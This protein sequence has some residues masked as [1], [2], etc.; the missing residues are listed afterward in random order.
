MR[1]I[2]FFDG[3][4]YA[5]NPYWHRRRCNR[6]HQSSI[7]REAI[8]QWSTMSKRVAV[9]VQGSISSNDEDRMSL[10]AATRR[11][12]G[13]TP[14]E[15]VGLEPNTL[16]CVQAV[17]IALLVARD[18]KLGAGMAAA[19][20][21]KYSVPYSSRTSTLFQVGMTVER[22]EYLSTGRWAQ[23]DQPITF[24]WCNKLENSILPA[25]LP[26]LTHLHKFWLGI[27]WLVASCLTLFYWVSSGFPRIL[28]FGSFRWNTSACCFINT[29]LHHTIPCSHD[30]YSSHCRAL[31]ML[32][33]FDRPSNTD[34]SHR[35]PPL[36]S[37]PVI[38]FR[39]LNWLKTLPEISSTFAKNWQVTVSSS[40]YLQHSV[41]LVLVVCRTRT[42]ILKPIS[43]PSCSNSH[44]PGFINHPKLKDAG[45]VF[46]IAVNDPFVW[47]LYPRLLLG[48]MHKSILSSLQGLFLSLFCFH[49]SFSMKETLNKTSLSSKITSLYH[50]PFVSSLIS[51]LFILNPPQFPPTQTPTISS[52]WLPNP[53]MKAWG[54]SLDAEKSSK[55]RF[56]G[57][58]SGA[59]TRALDTEFDSVKIFG[60]N[61]SKRYVVTVEDGKVK[62]V[63]IE[64][65][66]T[67][68]NGEF[69]I[70][71]FPAS[72]FCF[73]GVLIVNLGK[74]ANWICC[75][76]S[77]HSGESAR[78]DHRRSASE[79]WFRGPFVRGDRGV[80]GE[81]GGVSGWSERSIQ[82]CLRIRTGNRTTTTGL[83]GWRHSRSRPIEIHNSNSRLM[84]CY[85]SKAQIGKAL[86]LL[87]ATW[88]TRSLQRLTLCPRSREGQQHSVQCP[89]NK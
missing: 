28:I 7:W 10:Q 88:C 53:S 45:K 35:L 67:G 15:S 52:S 68:V 42:S 27:T 11:L 34:Y 8:G 33:F 23:T 19:T 22:Y 31:E 64:P 57:D 71:V 85:K 29:V 38:L 13:S 2:I 59:F 46:V 65:D 66:N 70:P 1:K 12:A 16:Y 41:R 4:I 73:F 77:I 56:L 47:V 61:R 5:I 30:R 69:M 48:F 32:I 37:K 51:Q 43:G 50:L 25:R 40:V 20:R 3:R 74:L 82:R 84:K 75:A 79:L 86:F 17:C 18:Q 36:W 81:D 58:P 26:D 9:R 54:A 87:P 62:E 76:W 63:F 80:L 55:I 49:P 78:L 39:L 83:I 24:T 72:V 44:V 21:P 60:Q 6:L 89:K 14:V